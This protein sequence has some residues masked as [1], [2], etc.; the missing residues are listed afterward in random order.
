M[1]NAI[2][3]IQANDGT[4]DLEIS[5]GSIALGDT[6]PQQ[7]YLMLATRPGDW[8][9]SPTLGIGIEDAAADDDTQYWVRETLEQFRRVGLAVKG[10]EF[11]GDSI[12][13]KH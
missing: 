10:V 12:Q 13:I 5:G 1:N 3:L 6:Q 9:E 7:E 4:V 8:K 2:R 11:T